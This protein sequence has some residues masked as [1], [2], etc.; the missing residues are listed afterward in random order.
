M[1]LPTTGGISAAMVNA[2]LGRAANAPLSLGEPAVRSLA[3]ILAG[4]I[5]YASLLGKSA[6]LVVNLSSGG[7]TV[8]VETLFTPGQWAS[9]TPKR[10]VIPEGVER[11]STVPSSAAVRVNTPWGG[12]LSIEVYGTVSGAGGAA[13][14]DGGNALAINSA[15]LSGQKAAVFVGSTGLI[16]AGGGGGGAGGAGGNGS[17]TGAVREPSTGSAY[18][19]S[20]TYFS[21]DVSPSGGLFYSDGRAFW[22][23]VQ[24][25]VRGVQAPVP[26]DVAEAGPDADGWL[27]TRDTLVAATYYRV[28]RSRSATLTSTGGA[29]GTGGVGQGYGQDRTYGTGGGL[30]SGTNAGNGGS[31][32]RGGPY[33]GSGGAGETGTNGS[34]TGG[35]PGLSGGLAGYAVN[36]AVNATITNNGTILGRT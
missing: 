4:G 28:Y 18:T 1:P 17:Y 22:G 35:S 36:N 29:G 15:G 32:G 20:S 21:V 26:V 25:A 23:G 5:S 10:V 34:V 16:R 13:G 14:A 27:Y 3:G 19:A 30:A 33:G 9:E 7:T 31:G 11:G 8:D 12:P 2:E 24:K 6:E